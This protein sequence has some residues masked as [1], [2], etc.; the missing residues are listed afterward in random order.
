MGDSDLAL[1]L[2]FEGKPVRVVMVDADAWFAAPD[3]C[4]ALEM[5]DVTS[6]LRALDADEKG[7]LTVRTPGGD[8][9]VNGVSEPG[10]Y[11]LIARP[12]GT[13]KVTTQVRITPKGLTRLAASFA[14]TLSGMPA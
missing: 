2:A 10:L 7:P 5:A 14:P 8:Q 3:V 12:D 1:A 6:A 4:R 9:I 11:K 13:E